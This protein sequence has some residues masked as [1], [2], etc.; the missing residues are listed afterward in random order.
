[1]KNLLPKLLTLLLWL[2]VSIPIYSADWDSFNYRGI[3]Y[4]V[5]SEAD[6]T[7]EV[8][9]NESFSG[10][11]DIPASVTYSGATYAVTEIGYEAFEGC[12]GL[13][14]VTIPNSVTTI[15]GGRS[16]DAAA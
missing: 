16:N 4:K 13:T 5:L 9:Y 12:S 6:K 10:H 1:M 14:S 11:A 7:V 15:K 3:N 2:T 8:A